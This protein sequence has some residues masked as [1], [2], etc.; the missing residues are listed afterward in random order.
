MGSVRVHEVCLRD[1]LQNEQTLVSTADKARVLRQLIAAG[2]KDIEVTSFVRPRMIPQFADARDL[3]AMIPEADGV[4]FWVLVPNLKGLD[5]ALDSFTKHI[6]TFMSVSDA[7]NRR[8]VNRTVRES[9]AGVSRVLRDARL[10]DLGT[11]AYLSTAFGCPYEGF[12]SPQ[13]TCELGLALLEAGAQTIALGD[14]TGMGTPAV[15]RDVLQT[16]FD[17]GVSPEQ[18][19]VHFHDTRGTALVNIHTSW[20]MGIR[21]FDGS[22]AGVGGCPYAHGAAGNACTQD[23]IHLFDS[24]GEEHGLS[25]EELCKAG[26]MLE[27]FLARELPGR[28][29]RYWM[30]SRGTS[31]E[32]ARA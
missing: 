16:F 20:A 27:R 22:V 4:R 18:L 14:T 2:C 29:H 5:R 23:A 8:N 9:L 21:H 28:Y 17:A 11:R 12:V 25:M 19:A 10:E 31:V 30:G 24:M 7:H 26:E 32:S 1:G 6:A 3:M 15:V 13:K